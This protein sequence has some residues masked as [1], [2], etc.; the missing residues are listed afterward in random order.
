MAINEQMTTLQTRRVQLLE[1]QQADLAITGRLQ[2]A[3]SQLSGA[4]SEITE[5]DEAL[6]RQTVETVKASRPTRFWSA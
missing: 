3:E 2:E 1:A 4:P 6:V 5:W